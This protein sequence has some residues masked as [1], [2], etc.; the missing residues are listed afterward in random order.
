MVQMKGLLVVRVDLI[1][2]FAD[3]PAEETTLLLAINTKS[4]PGSILKLQATL[5]AIRLH[6]CYIMPDY[7][8]TQV[9]VLS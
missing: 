7:V 6:S 4:R 5:V 8:I 3:A 2:V 9:S 1:P